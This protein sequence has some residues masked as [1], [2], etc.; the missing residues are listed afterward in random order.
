MI[1]KLFTLALVMA[2]LVGVGGAVRT[3]INSTTL[4][5]NAQSGTLAT[6]TTLDSTNN[7]YIAYGQGVILRVVESGGAA[8]GT[9]ITV[10]AGDD[11]PAFRKYLGNLTVTIANATAE[12]WIGP[13]E[14]ARFVNETGYLLVNTNT[15]DGTIE[16]FTFPGV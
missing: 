14:S 3:A 9:L 11:P 13:F 10:I 15:T 6:A 5:E 12:T 7:H 4:A 8:Y 1:K 16:A 2:L